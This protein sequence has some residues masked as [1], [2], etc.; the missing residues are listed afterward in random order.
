MYTLI[1]QIDNEK[2]T[3]QYTQFVLANQHKEIPYKDFEIYSV[4]KN[5]NIRHHANHVTTMIS[6]F[7]AKWNQVSISCLKFNSKYNCL[8]VGLT[9]GSIQIYRQ[10]SQKN[11]MISIKPHFSKIN[12]ISFNNEQ[13]MMITSSNDKSIKIFKLKKT[14]LNVTPQFV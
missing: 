3:S 9:D 12:D 14:G 11:N 1:S 8:F 6:K 2:L 13:S 10:S 4:D 5:N 7:S